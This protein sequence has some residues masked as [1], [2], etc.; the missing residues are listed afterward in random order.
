MEQELVG[1]VL[2]P[3]WIA[4]R[5]MYKYFKTNNWFQ[6]YWM[7]CVLFFATNERLHKNCGITNPYTFAK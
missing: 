3:L 2:I 6:T 5:Y 4:K 7:I 1:A